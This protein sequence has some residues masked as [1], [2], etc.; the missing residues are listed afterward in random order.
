[1]LAPFVLKKRRFNLV[2]QPLDVDADSAEQLKLRVEAFGYE[3]DPN[4]PFRVQPAVRRLREEPNRVL[5]VDRRNKLR[6]EMKQ[7]LRI[8]DNGGVGYRQLETG[9]AGF[10]CQ[11]RI[12][13]L[14][15]RHVEHPVSSKPLQNIAL[16]GDGTMEGAPICQLGLGLAGITHPVH[17]P[18]RQRGV[19]HL[20]MPLREELC[21]SSP[22]AFRVEMDARPPKRAETVIRT[23]EVPP[24]VRQE[25][26]LIHT[27]TRDSA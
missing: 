9:A 4:S 27:Q 8:D 19:E 1:M 6:K 16:A 22:E 26:C 17:A 5:P 20:D 23:S 14:L 10:Q 25:L 21:A 13:I 12:R 11:Q 7:R 18:S 2:G 3:Y 15:L 24:L